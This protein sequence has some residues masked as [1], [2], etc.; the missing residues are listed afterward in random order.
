HLLKAL[1]KVDE[2][3]TPYLLK[4]L[5]VNVINLESVLDSI[6]N[7]YPKVS[8][9]SGNQYLTND[10]N[11]ALQNAVSYLKEFKDEYVS[12]EHLLLGLLKVRDRTSQILKDA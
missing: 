2:N 12:V 5:N 10:A 4:K 7:S 8:G 3:V 11:A 6:L 9:N 1:L